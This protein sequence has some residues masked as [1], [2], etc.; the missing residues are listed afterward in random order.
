MQAALK[1]PRECRSD[2]GEPVT[3]KTPS[4]P[5]TAYIPVMF[6][7]PPLGSLAAEPTAALQ[8]PFQ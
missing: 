8:I 2:T 1:A 5:L 6:H 4:L 7:P 3:Y